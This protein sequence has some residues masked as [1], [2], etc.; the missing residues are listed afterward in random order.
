MKKEQTIGWDIGGAH[1][2]VVALDQEGTVIYVDQIE[3]PLWKGLDV[4]DQAFESIP[5]ELIKN[6][7]SHGITMTGELADI[8]PDRITGVRELVNKITVLL[9]QNVSQKINIYAGEKGWLEAGSIEGNETHIASANWHA[10]ASYAA[11]KIKTN[12]L[13]IDT[14]STTTDIIPLM[15]GKPDSAGFSDNERLQKDELVYTGVNRTSVTAV[16]SSL[17]FAGEW[18]QIAAE[19]FSTMGDIYCL[20]GDVPENAGFTTADGK[21]TSLLDCARRLARVTGSDLH[22]AELATW[23]E[24]AHYISRQQM[25]Q[26]S[27]SISRVRSRYPT[28]EMP[29]IGTGAGKFLIRRLAEWHNMPYH[30]FADF[31]QGDEM[32]KQAAAICVPATACAA[33]IKDIQP[34]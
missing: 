5:A 4:L 22:E 17:P 2:K 11:K 23:Q 20:T 7:K 34:I 3:T 19:Y 21:G 16:V 6:A 29:I 10:T 8:F 14:G 26:I 31:L 15:D 30:D 18:Q 24:L 33:L 27:A 25:Q 32:L 13:L 28:D 1:L 9:D 12:G